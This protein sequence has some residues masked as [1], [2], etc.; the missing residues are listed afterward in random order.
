VVQDAKQRDP[1]AVVVLTH[2]AKE[3]HVRAALAEVDRLA[4]VQATARVIRIAG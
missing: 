2:E 4:I 1:V 3:G